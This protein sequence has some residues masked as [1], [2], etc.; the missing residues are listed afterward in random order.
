M[1]L[2]FAWWIPTPPRPY[3]P[4]PPAASS[5]PPPRG[6]SLPRWAIVTDATSVEGEVD[7]QVA[8]GGAT[9]RP[10]G[11]AHEDRPEDRDFHGVGG[12]TGERSPAHSVGAEGFEPSLGTV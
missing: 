6:S 2:A 10:G 3:G 7:D 4:P 11:A 9:K 1:I 5:G 12:H 8:C